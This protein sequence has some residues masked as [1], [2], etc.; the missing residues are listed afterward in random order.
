MIN[1][2][3]L[4]LPKIDHDLI[5]MSYDN[6]PLS[7]LAII[8]NSFI[9]SY[10]HFNT[11]SSVELIMW[12][13]A[14]IVLTLWRFYTYKSFQKNIET[15]NIQKWKNTFLIGTTLSGILWGIAPIIMFNSH[16][17]ALQTLLLIIMVGMASGAI[18]SLA[19]DL[20]SIRIYLT[21]SL[22]PL[23]FILYLQN[24]E[25]YYIFT[26]TTI[27]YLIM[28]LIMGKHFHMNVRNTLT[29]Q[30][31]Y[32]HANNKLLIS[33][34]RFE[35]IFVHAPVGIFMYD[36]SM[37]II[38][39]NQI[40]A[41][42]LKAP[43]DKVIG[44]DMKKLKDK[45]VIPS[46]KSSLDGYNGYYEGQ[47]N[48]SISNEN[49]FISIQSS[50][51][52]NESA[53]VTGGIGIVSDITTQ[54]EAQKKIFRQAYYDALTD[55]P[56]RTLFMQILQKE[57]DH[58][59]DSKNISA[60]LFLDFDNFKNIN[61]SLGHNVG[62]SLL[63]QASHRLANS[64]RAKDTLS[65]LGGDEFV[66]ILTD[67]GQDIEFATQITKKIVQEILDT[68]KKPFTNINGHKLNISSSLGI[69]MLDH[70]GETKEDILKHADTA[71]YKAKEAGKDQMCFY[72]TNM[73]HM[74]QKRLELENALREAHTNGSLMVYFQPIID[75]PNHKII[76]AEA[77]IRWNHKTL[78]FI[79]PEE[80]IDIAENNGSI[81]EIGIW[82]FDEALKAF[83]SFQELSLS[84]TLS[85]ISI[86]I[87]AKQ[88]MNK[89]FVT[90]ILG[91]IH[92]YQIEATFIEI[93]LTESIII[94]NIQEVIQ[95]MNEIKSYGISISMDD[96]G[97]GYSSLSYLKKLPFSTLKIDKSFTHD[98]FTN[99][100]NESLVETTISIAKNF[101]LEI[102]AEGVETQEQY[103]FMKEKG[104]NYYQGFLCSPAVTSA[105]FINLLKQ[106]CI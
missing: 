95:K 66:I 53:D 11:I 38:E 5:K 68:I 105:E 15:T 90:D 23:A 72:S 78:G 29:A 9:L 101:N 24:Q 98:L 25:I 67:L 74:I 62:D 2:T 76:G 30:Y 56:N 85:K 54:K 51:L 50:P 75:I 18:N 32:L 61:D 99:K 42:I 65:R 41:D 100:N 87:S 79:N 55:I 70:D 28:M 89:N 17:I 91:V 43:L 48:T 40:F 84:H 80:L 3:N 13:G 19:A 21:T 33:Q 39:S 4:Y 82:V 12:Q 31:N 77:L 10:M 6:I 58:F 71:M 52:R 20:K 14:L 60:I 34:Q 83:K 59:S 92:K 22:L 94:K 104:C 47:Y 106:E 49:I 44:L 16:S 86:N 27:L 46:L 36:N 103:E 35:S 63:K 93:E 57:I 7:L 26:F 102:V 37:K 69:T 97:T 64:I 45:S 73:S 1:K 88:L 96:F 81:I 8:I